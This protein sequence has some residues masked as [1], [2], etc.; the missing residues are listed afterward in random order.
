MKNAIGDQFSIMFF[1][2]TGRHTIFFWNSGVPP[3]MVPVSHHVFSY[4]P[5]TRDI[6][7]NIFDHFHDFDFSFQLSSNFPTLMFAEF[8]L[9]FPQTIPGTV[10]A[11]SFSVRFPQ[12]ASRYGFRK[13]L[14]G[15]VSVKS[16]ILL[17]KYMKSENE[18]L[19]M[20]LLT[21]SMRSPPWIWQK[22]LLRWNVS[23]IP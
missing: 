7:W 13:K 22:K 3:K 6:F 20:V 23:N 14:P 21:F 4:L 19:T 8:V 5:K 10:S 1:H 2:N 16:Y 11:K 18:T 9:W 17:P 15:T 12:K